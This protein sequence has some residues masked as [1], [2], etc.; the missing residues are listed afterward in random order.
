MLRSYRDLIVWQKS[1]MLVEEIYVA[2]QQFPKEEVYG[3]I[4]QIRRVAV[5]IPSNIAEG[6][7]RG[8]R[9]EFKQFLS[10]AYGSG[11]EFETQREL[12]KRL[13]KSK[14]IDFT[15][16]EQLLNEVMKMLNT[17]IGTLHT[18]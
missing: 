15:K 4:S 12:S 8:S 6:R 2:T 5:S 1:M 3:L 7:L 16:V 9:K 13:F 17:L 10:Y 11:G 18:S 14:N